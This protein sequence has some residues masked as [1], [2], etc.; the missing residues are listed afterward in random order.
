VEHCSGDDV[1]RIAR[2]LEVRPY[3][4]RMYEKRRAIP[5]A[6]LPTVVLLGELDRA[7]R[8]RKLAGKGEG[9]GSGF[10]WIDRQSV[11]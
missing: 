3:F 5:R 7:P 11:T 2:A 1:I 8:H 9:G 4:E 6:T 10:V